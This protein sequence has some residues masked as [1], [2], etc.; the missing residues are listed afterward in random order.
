VQVSL[1][2]VIKLARGVSA[3]DGNQLCS[4]A[5]GCTL[6][7]ASPAMPD[8]DNSIPASTLPKE[9]VS[10]GKTAIRAVCLNRHT[11][12]QDERKANEGIM[13]ALD[14]ERQAALIAQQAAMERHL[15][16]LDAERRHQADLAAQLSQTQ[17]MPRR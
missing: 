7:C 11:A 2:N 13:Q 12:L 14:R 15:A 1:E 16:E 10:L 3:A 8:Q 9:K 17:V 4:H 6:C 5:L